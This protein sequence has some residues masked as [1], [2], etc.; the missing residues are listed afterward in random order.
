MHP[1]HAA[2]LRELEKLAALFSPLQIA[3]L[4]L[5]GA[6]IGVAGHTTVGGAI[7]GGVGG[8]LRTAGAAL[9]GRQNPLA[10]G[11][12]NPFQVASAGRQRLGA[13]TQRV[14]KTLQRN[15]ELIGQIGDAA[16]DVL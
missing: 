9:R 7:A 15:S 5:Q 14:G 2:Y 8:G 10:R 12:K 11:V 16:G 1:N 4:G 3:K 13:T 6:K